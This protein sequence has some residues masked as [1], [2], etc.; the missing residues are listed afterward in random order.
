MRVLAISDFH[1]A[2]ISYINNNTKGTLIMVYIH[3]KV[4]NYFNRNEF[5]MKHKGSSS[6]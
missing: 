3:K 2:Y 1:G 4:N 6:N 5:V